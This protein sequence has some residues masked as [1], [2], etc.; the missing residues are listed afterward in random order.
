MLTG[1]RIGNFQALA[2]TQY[3][4]IRPLTFILGPNSTGNSMGKQGHS[5]SPWFFRPYANS[6]SMTKNVECPLVLSRFSRMRGRTNQ[7]PQQQAIR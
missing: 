5:V 6:G 1:L 2:D 4:P 7:A 3:I